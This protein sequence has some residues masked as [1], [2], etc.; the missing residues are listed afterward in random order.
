MHACLAAAAA[1]AQLCLVLKCLIY[2]VGVSEPCYKIHIARQEAFLFPYQ[3]TMSCVRTCVYEG[4]DTSNQADD[5]WI[6]TYI[7][8][9]FTVVAFLEKSRQITSAY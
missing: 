6:V 7:L 8:R 3:R 9:Y 5:S 4:T 2:G 1:A